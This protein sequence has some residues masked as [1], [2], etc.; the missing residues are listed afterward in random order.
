M[1]E[2]EIQFVLEND[3]GLRFNQMF[4]ATIFC[5]F[6]EKLTQLSGEMEPDNAILPDFT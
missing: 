2:L 4:S 6:G 3:S 1:E 5:V